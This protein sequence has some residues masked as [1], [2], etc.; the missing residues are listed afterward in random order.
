GSGLVAA[1]QFSTAISPE[2]KEF[3]EQH[4]RK[5]EVKISDEPEPD[6]KKLGVALGPSRLV[7]LALGVLILALLYRNVE[8]LGRLSVIFLVGVLGVLGWVLFDG[9]VRFDP[10]LAFDTTLAERERPE[11]FGLAL[12]AGMGLA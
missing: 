2:F 1:A 4:T 8:S 9:A 7:G 12:G 6:G 3:D 11:H 5:F 10:S